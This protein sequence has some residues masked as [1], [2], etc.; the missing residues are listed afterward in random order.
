MVAE[1]PDRDE[2]FNAAA[3]LKD[4]VQRAEYLDQAADQQIG[5]DAR[6]KEKPDTL[7]DFGSCRFMRAFTSPGEAP[8]SRVIVSTSTP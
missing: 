6:C 8:R 3:E 4:A 5:A 7:Q 1:R 2:I